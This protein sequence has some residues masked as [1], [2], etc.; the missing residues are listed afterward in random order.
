MELFYGQESVLFTPVH[1]M[2]S[3]FEIFPKMHII[4]QNI[5]LKLIRITSCH[6]RK[7]S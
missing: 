6:M 4:R 5:L 1:D 3:P 2:M 7:N